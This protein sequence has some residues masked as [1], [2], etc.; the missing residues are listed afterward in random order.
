MKRRSC[1]IAAA[2]LILLCTS[3]AKQQWRASQRLNAMRQNDSYV[4]THLVV[5]GETL[6]RIAENY[7]QDAGQADRIAA[8]NGLLDPA[9]LT[10]GSAL[11]LS[12]TLDEWAAAEPR[13]LAMQP[14]NLGV[15]AF[16]RGD[17]DLADQQFRQAV[18]LDKSFVDAWYN[19]SL[20]ESRRGRHDKAAEILRR[21]L[22]DDPQNAEL[23]FALGNVRFY[24]TEFDGAAGLFRS[25]LEYQPAHRQAAYALAR[26]LG[27]AGRSREAIA[28]WEAY[29]RLDADSIWS[30]RARAQ[31]DSLRGN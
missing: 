7:Y 23:L 22:K 19:L 18:D 9:D 11:I 26:S 6:S 17:L 20:V 28:A 4:L 31:L 24:Q 3:C 14:Y 21:L 16:R 10:V 30:E 1:L 13:Y 29:L 2:L 8:E 25:V 5:E 27:E 15:E 12:F